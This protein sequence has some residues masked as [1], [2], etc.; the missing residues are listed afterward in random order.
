[1]P[2]IPD[3]VYRATFKKSVENQSWQKWQMMRMECKKIVT[4]QKSANNPLLHFLGRGKQPK[5]TVYSK[6]IPNLKKNKWPFGCLQPIRDQFFFFHLRHVKLSFKYIYNFFFEFFLGGSFFTKTNGLFTRLNIMW[7]DRNTP[8]IILLYGTY[9][10]P[11]LG[12]W[13]NKYAPK[14]PKY[15]AKC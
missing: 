9:F 7:L 6:V 8:T 13:G 2:P 14:G 10:E 15:Q 11:Y 3:N 5:T 12:P 1:M 4:F